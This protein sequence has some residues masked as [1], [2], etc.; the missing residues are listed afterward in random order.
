ME[1][2][3][4]PPCEG[5]FGN[6]HS[7]VRQTPRTGGGWN[8]WDYYPRILCLTIL[9]SA[10]LA[11]GNWRP[12]LALLVGSTLWG[13]AREYRLLFLE[14]LFEISALAHAYAR[15]KLSPH[16]PASPWHAEASRA[17]LGVTHFTVGDTRLCKIVYE[18]RSGRVQQLLCHG[19]P[20]GPPSG[21]Y[22]LDFADGSSVR[23]SGTPGVHTPVTSRQ[24]GAI[25]AH[26][27]SL[28]CVGEGSAWVEGLDLDAPLGDV[29]RRRAPVSVRGRFVRA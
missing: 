26:Y 16:H 20:P 2:E 8:V 23:F 28:E 13:N 17:N 15:A 21:V 27:H 1:A 24:L 25:S 14:R 18:E 7:P 12:F 29:A 10:I 5:A 19:L 22:I 4:N 11:T 3:P 6:T 9:F